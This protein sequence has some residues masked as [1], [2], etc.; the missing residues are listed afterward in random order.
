M[1]AEDDLQ[2]AGD[3]SAGHCRELLSA[4]RVSRLA[5]VEDGRPR[6]VVLNHVVDNE[7]LVFQT[8]PDTTLARLTAGGAVIPATFETGSASG[9]ARA[10]WSIVASG[11]LSQTTAADATHRPK[12]WRREAV[13]VLL[14]LE[15]DEIHGLEVGPWTP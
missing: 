3:M 1:G 2:A 15:I 14:R 7:D 6:V 12:P 9:A 10:G 8:S 11:L 4:T 5:F 13:G